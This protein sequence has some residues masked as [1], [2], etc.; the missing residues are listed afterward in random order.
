MK[1]VM[2]YRIGRERAGDAS[3]IGTDVEQQAARLC[4]QAVECESCAKRADDQ[5]REDRQPVARIRQC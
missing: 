2:T 3:G 5:R 4:Q 1:Q